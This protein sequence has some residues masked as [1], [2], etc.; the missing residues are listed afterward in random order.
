MLQRIRIAGIG[1]HAD[2]TVT[3]GARV[4]VS[5]PSESGKSTVIDALC[6]LLWGRARDGKALGALA[7]GGVAVEAVTAKGSVISR[8]QAAGGAASMTLGHD[9][10]DTQRDFSAALKVLGDEDRIRPLLVP[11]GWVGLLQGPGEGRPLREWLVRHLPGESMDTVL[12]DIRPGEADGKDHVARVKQAAAVVTRANKCVDRAAGMLEE[13]E[14]AAPIAPTAPDPERVAELRALAARR[15]EQVQAEADAKAAVKAWQAAVTAHRKAADDARRWDEGMAAIHAPKADRPAADELTAALDAKV[16]AQTAADDARRAKLDVEATIQR[17]QKRVA[18]ASETIASL[19][20]EPKPGGC[21]G[22]KRGC[23]IAADADMAIERWRDRRSKAEAA[24]AE[25]EAV[26]DVARAQLPAAAEA[27]TIAEQAASE[28]RAAYLRLQDAQLKW[29]A[30][31]AAVAKLGPRPTVPEDPGPQPPI[32]SVD[33]LPDD[34][35]AVLQYETALA[36]H[37]RDLANREERIRDLR[38]ALEQAKSAAERAS[39]VLATLRAAPGRVLG[40]RLA[41]LTTGPARFV[42]AEDG[43]SIDL[44]IDGRPWHVASHGRQIVADAWLRRGLADA[45]GLRW[46]AV[47]VDGVES[48]NGAAQA[49]PPGS[50]WVLRSTPTDALT[51]RVLDAS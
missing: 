39:W 31:D 19:G 2:T 43:E 24:Q 28:A 27:V 10:Y 47:I 20:A 21:A 13:A 29:S 6:W 25:A 36:F 12:A 7:R 35:D 49:L 5:G 3:L 40:A 14:R 11:F 18:D 1:P 4:E 44:Q 30:F 15:A 38:S 48:V 51:T 9:V 37:R 33:P 41:S 17:A 45:M 26:R 23:S 34:A 46:I 8:R 16:R 32:P 50:L 42:V 22:V